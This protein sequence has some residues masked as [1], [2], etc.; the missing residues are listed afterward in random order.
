MWMADIV[1]LALGVVVAVLLWRWPHDETR[2]EA[3]SIDGETRAYAVALCALLL[4]TPVAWVHHYVWV[5]PAAAIALGYAAAH[6]LSAPSRATA[7]VLAIV[8]LACLA[9]IWP[10]PYAWDTEP[11]PAVTTLLGLPMRPLALELRALGTLALM[12]VLASGVVAALWREPSHPGE[13][14]RQVE[15][16]RQA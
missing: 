4:L 6:W 16:G 1:R 13:R 11:T 2:A 3:G 5:L 7:L 12:G 14:I 8:V 10:L 15:R 9:L